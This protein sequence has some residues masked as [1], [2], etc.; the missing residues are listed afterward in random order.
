MAQDVVERDLAREMALAGAGYP[1]DE[2]SSIW[3]QSVDILKNVILVGYLT[4][5]LSVFDIHYL[6]KV[7]RKA[8]SIG[9]QEGRNS[10]WFAIFKDIASRRYPRLDVMK[11]AVEAKFLGDRLALEVDYKKLVLAIS[12]R[13]ELQD[14]WMRY[15]NNPTY[16]NFSSDGNMYLYHNPQLTAEDRQIAREDIFEALGQIIGR[17][18][19]RTEIA[20]SDPD[21]IQLGVLHTPFYYLLL[22]NDFYIG[23]WDRQKNEVHQRIDTRRRA[24]PSK[25]TRFKRGPVIIDEEGNPVIDEEDEY[26]FVPNLFINQ[27]I[28]CG[29]EAKKRCVETK[30]LYCSKGCQIKHIYKTF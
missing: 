5:R 19:L 2:L 22:I 10:I 12:M 4:N 26:P 16:I 17:D 29:L 13:N 3:A 11:D 30:Q 14:L 6:T 18:K 28:N 27:C 21:A 15:G 25:A 23:A 7:N 20:R 9:A 8:R 24:P 1:V